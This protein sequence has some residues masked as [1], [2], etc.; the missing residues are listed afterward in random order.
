MKSSREPVKSFFKIFRSKERERERVE[1][2]ATITW[3][4][5][6]WVLW[7]MWKVLWW[8]HLRWLLLQLFSRMLRMFY[9]ERR[10]RTFFIFLFFQDFFTSL[11]SSIKLAYNIYPICYILHFTHLLIHTLTF[12][13]IT[14]TYVTLEPQFLDFAPH[15]SSRIN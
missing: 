4:R 11:R 14:H 1:K 7:E 15:V 8:A 12:K 13:A 9:R 5:S 3:P 6:R 10:M 2:N